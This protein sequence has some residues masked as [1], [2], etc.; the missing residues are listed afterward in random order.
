MDRRS[1]A[2]VLD[3]EVRGA[4]DAKVATNPLSM[5]ACTSRV[6]TTGAAICAMLLMASCG[7]SSAPDQQT[8]GPLGSIVKATKGAV[9]LAAVRHPFALSEVPTSWLELPMTGTIEIDAD[10]TIPIVAG[11]RDYA[12]A[13]GSL[14]ARC[15]GTC[16][17]GDDLARL[18]FPFFGDS[19]AFSHL[20]FTDV[21][22]R[23][24]VADGHALLS[25]W[26]LRSPDL[27]VHLELDLALATPL[28]DS[29]V[30]GC[31]R[32]KPTDALQARD[33]HL[34]MLVSLT[35]ADRDG[36]GAFTV[37]LAGTAGALRVQPGTCRALAQ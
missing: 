25:G 31:V 9:R 17:I 27:E 19:V 2:V 20:D 28:D 6:R 7:S 30:K 3:D 22:A 11:A 35:G 34:H 21:E 36:S 16:R 1:G 18:T 29:R 23:V 33:P 10:L 15:V 8:R 4:I 32:F 14:A 26:H 12:R 24:T 5:T 13:H 37:V